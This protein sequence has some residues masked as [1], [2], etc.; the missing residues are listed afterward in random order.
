MS[1]N[2]YELTSSSTGSRHWRNRQSA[3]C[4]FN[5]HPEFQQQS[6]RHFRYVRQVHHSSGALF[7]QF[8]GHFRACNQLKYYFRLNY[9]LASTKAKKWWKTIN[10]WRK[11]L[12]YGL[13]PVVANFHCCRSFARRLASRIH[14][15]VVCEG[16]Y[17]QGLHLKLHNFS[18]DNGRGN[19]L[20]WSPGQR[21]IP[22]R[23]EIYGDQG[24]R[25][26]NDSFPEPL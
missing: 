13:K 19:I 23:W 11:W 20:H 14:D 16:N 26:N 25:Y 6:L 8:G 9:P 3:P 10:N 2:I 12:I 24:E 18:G 5:S 21:R 17:S 4:F 22:S 1:L 7:T 15:D